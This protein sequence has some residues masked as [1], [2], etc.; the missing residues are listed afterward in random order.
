VR[1]PNLS[2]RKD[3][4]PAREAL[5]QADSATPISARS[6]S[7]RIST[8]SISRNFWNP[9]AQAAP[10]FSKSATRRRRDSSVGRS[11]ATPR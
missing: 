8:I 3:N 1:S 7:W 4:G 5:A 11:K 2:V 9:D 10:K 6:T